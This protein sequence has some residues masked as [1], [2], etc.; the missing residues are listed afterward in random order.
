MSVAV[1]SIGRGNAKSA[2]AAAL[3]VT[4]LVG[5]WDAQPQRE[6]V[7]AGRTKDQAAIAFRFAQTFLENLPDDLVTF[8]KV[9][10]REH[11]HFS[12]KLF[13]PDGPHEL[14]A[15]SADGKTALGGSATLVICDERA[16]WRPGRGE[17][18]EAALLTSLGKRDGKMLI[19]STS[20]PDDTN[21][22][23]QWCDNPPT[24]CYVQE[25]RPAPNQDADD[26]DSLMV[27][28]PGSEA[29]IGARPEWLIQQAQQ[30]IQRGG[31]ALAAFRN[32]HRNERVAAEGRDM[33]VQT[34][35]W[36]KCET[37][38]LPPRDGKVII[39]LDLG[40]ASSMTASAFLWPDTQRLEVRGWFPSSPDLLARG[41]NDHVGDRYTHM[42]R[43][44]SLRTIGDQT[45]P[46]RQWIRETLEH[47]GPSKI[48]A[49]VAD[50]FKQAEVGEALAAEG[51]NARVVW[52][53]MGW[54]D[55][56][57]DVRRFQRAVVDQQI[58]AEKTLLMRAALSDCV[59]ALDE[60]GNGKV[61]KARSTGRIDPA[62]AAVLAVAEASRLAS[63]PRR[64]ARGLVWA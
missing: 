8:E 12:L 22:F 40:G 46:I 7:I 19:I 14:R 20:A 39:G 27:A 51:V 52:R 11:P 32:L 60:S 1:W 26:F 47:V 5:C 59:V 15:I 56:S 2:T 43:E 63:R 30:A 36:L 16:A 33:L 54:R 34:D 41:H 50:R 18:M 28:N 53:G 9:Q 61:S 58:A 49:I 17:E 55:G 42:E 62:C 48:E 31:S 44:G 64:Q 3:A 13:G 37:D 6:V 21:S 23:S 29:G 57:E 35:D 4:H 25:H 38:S 45:V 24:A 10:T